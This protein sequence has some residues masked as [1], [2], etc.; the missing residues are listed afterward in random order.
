VLSAVDEEVWMDNGHVPDIRATTHRIGYSPANQINTDQAVAIVG[1]VTETEPDLV[2]VSIE[3]APEESTIDPGETV[4]L[5]TIAQPSR[6][7]TVDPLLLGSMFDLTPAEARL[8]LS[9]SAGR[10]SGE[11][12]RELGTAISTVRSQLKA[13]LAKTGTHRQ[14]ELVR[15]LS[16]LANI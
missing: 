13:V 12:A 1:A 4:A 7:S 15:L 8:A 5:V 10:T 3:I 2:P 16:E 9:L 14:V 11:V 6:A